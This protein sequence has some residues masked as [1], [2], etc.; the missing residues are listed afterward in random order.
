MGPWIFGSRWF[1]ITLC[2][3]IFCLG[4]TLVGLGATWVNRYYGIVSGDA[5]AHLKHAPR[6]GIKSRTCG[7]IYISFASGLWMT[8]VGTQVIILAFVLFGV[9]LWVRITCTTFER[10]RLD[11]LW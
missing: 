3:A 1:T 11:V 2:L 9:S 5:D 10:R 6:Q 4:L 8:V 7:L